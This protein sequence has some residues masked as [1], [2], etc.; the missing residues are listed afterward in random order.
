MINGGVSRSGGKRT[1]GFLYWY[2]YSVYA[3]NLRDPLSSDVRTAR[4]LNF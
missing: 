4:K 2:T 3:K 1:E